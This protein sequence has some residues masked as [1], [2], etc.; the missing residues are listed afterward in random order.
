[1]QGSANV[2]QGINYAI[3]T[4]IC[5]LVMRVHAHL[6]PLKLDSDDL[7]GE[8]DLWRLIFIYFLLFIHAV[9]IPFKGTDIIT[10]LLVISGP[11]V[12]LYAIYRYR[13]EEEDESLIQSLG[14]SVNEDVESLNQFMRQASSRSPASEEDELELTSTQ[15]H[16]SSMEEPGAGKNRI[17]CPHLRSEE[18]SSSSEEHCSKKT[19]KRPILDNQVSKCAQPALRSQSSPTTP[20]VVYARLP[21]PYRDEE[22]STVVEKDN[23]SLAVLDIQE[24]DSNSNFVEKD[25]ESTTSLVV[26]GDEHTAFFSDKGEEPTADFVEK[27]GEPTTT[28]L[29]D[30][31]E[32]QITIFAGKFQEPTIGVVEMNQGSTAG[33]FNEG[34]ELPTS[35][36]GESTTSSVDKCQELTT[37]F[38]EDEKPTR[39]VINEE[40]GHAACFFDEHQEPTINYIEEF[41][42][43][44][45]VK[46]KEL[47]N[48]DKMIAML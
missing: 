40:K 43:N 48:L 41:A 9:G 32:M 18:P 35:T 33:I 12:T 6:Q 45:F 42:T 1:M 10:I 17:P 47:K 28:S 2:L 38:E 19:N 14:V 11:V 7:V 36:I 3:A 24:D 16:L 39:S 4:V 21:T 23:K 8:F 15:Y 5:I 46:D 26:K 27:D 31:H 25:K 13:D 29:V 20:S 22:C 34:E 37:S 44:H 30:E